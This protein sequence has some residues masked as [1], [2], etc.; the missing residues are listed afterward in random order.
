MF[1]PFLPQDI[2]LCFEKLLKR[3]R[4]VAAGAVVLQPL[5]VELVALRKLCANHDTKFKLLED[6]SSNMR[7]RVEVELTSTACIVQQPIISMLIL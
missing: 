6:T 5:K 4:D 1:P 3:Q 2:K 7:A